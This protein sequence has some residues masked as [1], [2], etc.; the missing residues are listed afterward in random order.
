V[1]KIYL[2]VQCNAQRWTE[3]K[4]TFVSELRPLSLVSSKL[5]VLTRVLDKA[6]K[7]ST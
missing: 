1:A 3:H 2:S 5:H 7:T 4:I 6:V